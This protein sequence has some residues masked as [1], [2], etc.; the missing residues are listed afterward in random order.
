[1]IDLPIG[2]KFRDFLS[3]LFSYALVG[4]LSNIAV[5]SVY[6]VF[7]YLGA[8]PKI[9][10][11]L[12][13]SVGAAVGFVGNRSITFK[14]QGCLLGTG[15]RYIIAHSCGYLINLGILIMMVDKFGYAHQWV[16]AFAIL[17]VA[18]F[19]FLVFKFFVFRNIDVLNKEK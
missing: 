6:L 4:I 14:D 17:V 16:Q 3:Q 11:T 10:M 12:L 1:M 7:T 8:S 19:L 15:L 13:Y 2:N 9:T 18:V 5:Y